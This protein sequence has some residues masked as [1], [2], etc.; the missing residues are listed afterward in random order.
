MTFLF[1]IL[2]FILLLILMAGGMLLLFNILYRVDNR[3][4]KS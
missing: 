4:D 1:I 2:G 3:K